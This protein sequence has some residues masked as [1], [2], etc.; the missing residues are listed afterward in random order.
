MSAER[1]QRSA[2]RSGVARPER[3]ALVGLI[4]G[5]A[6]RLEA[7]NSLDELAGLAHA[8]G[9]DVV[10]RVLQERPKPDASTFLGSGKI[11]TLATSAAE[12]DVDVVIFDNELTPAQ[13]RQIEQEIGRKI[14]DRT[15]L[16]LDIFARRA[17][18]R[19]GKL[20]VELAQLK[21]LLPRLVG[22][23]AAL[24]R[25]GGGIGTRGPGET[26]LE[27]DRRR[28][29]TRIHVLGDDIEQVRR[30]RSQLRDRRHKTSVPTV[31]LVGYT[32]AGKTTLFNVL[33]SADA[34]A[35][36]ALFVTLDPLVRRLR[37]PDSRELLVSD[38]VGFIDRLPH[39]L[40]AAFRAT[41][42]ETAEA[43]LVL[44]VIDAAASDR[45]RRMNAVRRVL[46]EVGATDVPM[47]EVYNKSDA[48]T[49][50]ERRRLQDQDPS[51]LLISALQ[52]Q[53]IV[54]LVE[55]ITSRLALDVRRVVL[56]F[57]PDSASDRERI[58]RVYRHA[59]V[60]L[61]EARDGQ[62]SITADVPRRLLS[63]LG[64]AEEK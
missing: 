59:R 21:Y 22:S 28:I 45:E 37:L 38:T 61:H 29:R 17:R 52:R 54:E 5:Q 9:A 27:A 16:I 58:A 47:L 13:L 3:A 51:A 49:P 41:L 33:T 18:T 26:K 35:S 11:K 6:R 31:A 50:D 56:S 63:R 10:L 20:Q 4:T 15:Q 34:D 7:E 46:E 43:D 19:E 2:G 24:S 44:H 64:H 40:V 32:N 30:R 53:G 42:E 23:N 12:M 25:L 60:L 8:A 62:V 1:T 55:T 48:L 14:V 57:D 36:D 39:A